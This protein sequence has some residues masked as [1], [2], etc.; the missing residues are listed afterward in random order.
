MMADF[1][2]V[3]MEVLALR[4]EEGFHGLF[5][6]AG[7]QKGTG[8]VADSEGQGIVVDSFSGREAGG[9]GEDFYLGAGEVEG[10]LGM[11]VD[12]FDVE[13]GGGL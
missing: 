6:V 10:W 1:Q 7:E 5:H 12:Y 13:A 9:R 4:E 8:S 11:L 3:G 2:D